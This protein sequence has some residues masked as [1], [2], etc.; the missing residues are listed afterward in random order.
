MA[1]RDRLGEGSTGEVDR[2]RDNDPLGEDA[3]LQACEGG[4]DAD[5][6][7]PQMLTRLPRLD[8][9]AGPRTVGAGHDRRP[10]VCS[11]ACLSHLSNR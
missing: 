3:G 2:R 1:G 6:R 9:F 7:S 8:A 10:T 4:H 11:Y 5:A